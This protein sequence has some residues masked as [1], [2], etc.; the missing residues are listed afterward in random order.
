MA[1]PAGVN[2]VR[3]MKTTSYD[4][5]AA[6]KLNELIKDIG[7]AMLTTQT[8]DGSLRSRPMGTPGEVDNGYLWFFTA[9]DS[10]KAGEVAR[11][12]H[13]N[14]S[15]AEPK[16]NKYVSVSGRGE[17][18]HDRARSERLWNPIL[19]AWFPQGVDDPR[20][21]LLRVR[22]ETAEYWDAGSSRMVAFFKLAKA[23][24]TGH[25]PADLG[26]HEKLKVRATV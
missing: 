23:A 26:E 24:M 6:E 20:L 3:W 14:V 17:V 11:E 5:A 1:G 2:Y 22:I 13:V 25:A 10:G 19:K 16:Q 4:P 21:A 15:Y 8:A 9:D 7:I 12:H 18:V